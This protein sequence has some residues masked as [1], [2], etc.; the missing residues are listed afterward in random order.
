MTITIGEINVSIPNGIS[1]WVHQNNDNET[2]FNGMIE[3]MMYAVKTFYKNK[4][5]PNPYQEIYEQQVKE[6]MG[7]NC[8]SREDADKYIKELIKI[9]YNHT[10]NQCDEDGSNTLINLIKEINNK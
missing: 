3:S 5:K 6:L 2:E 10:N 4:Y 9:A 8:E 1:D 7:L